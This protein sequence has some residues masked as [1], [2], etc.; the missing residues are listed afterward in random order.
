ADLDH[1]LKRVP[2]DLEGLINKAYALSN[3]GEIHSDL[4]EYDRA[5]SYFEAAVLAYEA[6]LAIKNDLTARNNKAYAMAGL[7]QSF[8][9]GLQFDK[10]IESSRAAVAEY[11]EILRVSPEDHTVHSNRARA[12]AV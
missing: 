9:R 3:L 4:A 8:T 2:N 5:T 6:A 7:A 12:L 1:V 11:D 10:S